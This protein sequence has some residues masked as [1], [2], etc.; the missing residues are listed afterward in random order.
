M[1]QQKSEL[2][3][4]SRKG[5]ENGGG[6]SSRMLGRREK[7]REKDYQGKKALDD[8]IEEETKG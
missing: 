1:G 5:A 8:R 2:G 4:V 3:S 6:R 7:E